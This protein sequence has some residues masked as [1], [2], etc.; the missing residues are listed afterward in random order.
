MTHLSSAVDF[1]FLLLTCGSAAAAATTTTTAAAAAA[2][3]A[4]SL[5][6]T[7]G[8]RLRLR[9]HIHRF[10][11][12]LILLADLLP[13]RRSY[14]PLCA[15]SSDKLLVGIDFLFLIGFF[16]VALLAESQLLAHR[17]FE[18]DVALLLLRQ[19]AFCRRLAPHGPIYFLSSSHKKCLKILK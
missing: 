6:S 18:L 17:R 3:G 13:L 16:L 7:L 1:S 2:A 5:C 9:L 11:L 15:V 19:I 10:E 14:H 12:L 8:L 4:R